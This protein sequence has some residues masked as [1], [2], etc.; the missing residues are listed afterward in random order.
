[1]VRPVLILSN[2]PEAESCVAALEAALQD[3]GCPDIVNTDGIAVEQTAVRQRE[4]CL[5]TQEIPSPKQHTHTKMG[6]IARL[7][8]LTN[9]Y[10]ACRLAGV[11]NKYRRLQF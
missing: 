6:A 8:P 7:L 9:P 1:M 4:Q 5:M 10:T 11:R 3:Y 2:T